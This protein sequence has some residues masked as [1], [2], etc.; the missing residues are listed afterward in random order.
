[1]SSLVLGTLWLLLPHR[2]FYCY[3]IKN[4]PLGRRGGDRGGEVHRQIRIKCV[5]GLSPRNL[6]TLYEEEEDS[7]GSILGDQTTLLKATWQVAGHRA[8][9]TT[10]PVWEHR[11]CPTMVTWLCPLLCHPI[12]QAFSILTQERQWFSC[13]VQVLQQVSLISKR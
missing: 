13:S 6:L 12:S 3:Y 9:I 4:E 8:N 10:S 5:Y 1:M 2:C 11:L 7:R